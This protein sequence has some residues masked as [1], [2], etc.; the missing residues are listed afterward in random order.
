MEFP[1]M[2]LASKL[3]FYFEKRVQFKGIGLFQAR[4]VDVGGLFAQPLRRDRA[5]R[6]ATIDVRFGIV[7]RRLRD[8]LHLPLLRRQRRVQ[9]P[10]GGRPGSRPDR[11]AGAGRRR[12]G[13][14][15]R[16]GLRRA[17]PGSCARAAVR[18]AA[19]A[20]A[21]AD[22]RMGG[23]SDR[24]PPRAR[25][26]E[27]R[28]PSWPRDFRGPLRDRS[29]QLEERRRTSS[30]SCFRS[31]RKKTGE[32]GAIKELP[33]HRVAGRAAAGPGR[34]GGDHAAAGRPGPRRCTR[35]SRRT[36]PTQQS[37]AAGA[38]A[39]APA[40]ARRDRPAL[41]PAG[42]LFDGPL[43]AALGRRRAVAVHP[44]SAAG[45]PRPVEHHRHACAAAKSGWS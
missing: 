17:I 37:A 24:H 16:G 1:P 30:W 4:R 14:A 12:P 18:S 40:D 25:A 5:R 10:L 31:T 8:F 19:A 23:A 22:S 36:A 33:R 29:R 44:R 15:G 13:P 21:A 3:A 34:R 42:E 45:R 6:I 38:R 39:E 26:Q 32:W 20:A 2:P 27:G 41:L 28:P 7:D 43:A 35:T 9:A 11:R